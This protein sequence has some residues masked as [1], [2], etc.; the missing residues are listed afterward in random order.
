[1]ALAPE[2]GP[3]VADI[4]FKRLPPEGVFRSRAGDSVLIHRL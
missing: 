3:F 2:L 1:M 4:A